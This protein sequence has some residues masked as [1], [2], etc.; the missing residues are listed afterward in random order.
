MLSSFRQFSVFTVECTD[1]NF[2]NDPFPMFCEARLK[3][4]FA[5]MQMD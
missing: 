4:I 5:N 1:Q 3:T 2:E